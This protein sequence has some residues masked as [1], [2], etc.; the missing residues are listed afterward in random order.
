MH[1]VSII[2]LWENN[3]MDCLI[4][5]AVT[6]ILQTLIIIW[7]TSSRALLLLNMSPAANFES[8]KV[9]FLCEFG[10]GGGSGL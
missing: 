6:L 7:K 4:P 10:G 8:I 2:I 5:L 3:C 1:A 9:L